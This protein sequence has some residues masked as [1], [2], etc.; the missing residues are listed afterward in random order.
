[1]SRHSFAGQRDSQ[2]RETHL[3]DLRRAHAR[4]NLAAKLLRLVASL[5]VAGASVWVVVGPALYEQQV[6]HDAAPGVFAWAVVMFFIASAVA[7]TYREGE[8]VI[9]RIFDPTFQMAAVLHLR[10]ERGRR[11]SRSH[12]EDALHQIATRGLSEHR[13]VTHHALAEAAD[14]TIER[15]EYLNAIV[16]MSHGTIS[17]ITDP[18]YE[19]IDPV[20]GDTDES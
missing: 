12:L 11:F 10:A 17:E 6:V 14:L 8:Q 16:L 4:V 19:F 3:A 18:W 20:R 5:V 1:M 15:L 2:V 7:A 13:I 9:R